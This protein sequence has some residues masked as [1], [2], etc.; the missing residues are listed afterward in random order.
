[1]TRLT[2]RFGVQP[3]HHFDYVA[4]ITPEW[5]LT[6]G[7]RG[8]LVDADDT[9]VPGDNSPIAVDAIAWVTA[10]QRA[11]ITVAILSN[12]TP[13]RV[14][15]LGERLSVATFALSGKPFPSAF[16]RALKAIDRK[17]NE[18]V[19][20]GDQLFTDVMGARW[21][22]LCAILVTPLTRGRH[23]H[24]RAIRRLENWVLGTPHR[25]RAEQR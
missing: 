5:L 25:V 22:G 6:H 10:L 17:P 8:V 12:G 9:L 1:M 23:A 11:G 20:I 2:R 15:A 18:T 24:T 14:S 21:S 19:M 13:A 4:Q 7:L 16:Q 3:D